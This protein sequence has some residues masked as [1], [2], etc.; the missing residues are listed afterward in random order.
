MGHS[1]CPSFIFVKGLSVS[2]SF[3]V[4]NLCFFVEQFYLNEDNNV[5]RAKD[6]AF[7]FS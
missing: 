1:G 3:C 6:Y 2:Q 7:F 4:W 5:G